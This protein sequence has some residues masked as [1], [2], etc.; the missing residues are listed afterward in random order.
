MSILQVLTIHLTKLTSSQ[1][2]NLLNRK[3]HCRLCGRVVCGNPLTGCSS[4]VGLNV[5]G[6]IPISSHLLT[7]VHSEKQLSPEVRVDVRM[8]QDCKSTIFGRRDFLNDSTKTPKYVAIYENMSQFRYGIEQ[9][10]PKFKSLV[11]LLKESETVPT[12][13][14]LDEAH[15]I[16]KRLLD[17]FTQY[18]SVSKRI[19]QSSSPTE[20]DRRVQAA[21]NQAATHFLQTH[22]LPLQSLPKILKSK[23]KS[24]L[25]ADGSETNGGI[26]DAREKELKE[27]MM[28]LEEQKY[29]VGNMM[30]TARKGRRTEEMGALK[31][32]L[33]DLDKE[34]ENI[35][36]ELGDLFIE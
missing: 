34:I 33:D 19:L 13:A 21:M 36:Q 1:Q 28:V 30:E 26:S 24:P 16:R 4:N 27:K 32:S 7:S 12:K 5:S 3:H 35:K 25:S 31:E 11:F 20:T 22:M 10:L 6:G 29:L 9:L 14:Q 8:C 18:D 17:L 2:F 15:K 23:D